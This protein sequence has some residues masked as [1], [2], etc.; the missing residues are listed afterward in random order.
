MSRM[1]AP[2]LLLLAAWFPAAPR[3]GEEPRSLAWCYRTLADVVCYTDPDAGR[4]NRFVGAYPFRPDAAHRLLRERSGRR[5]AALAPT[6]W[7]PAPPRPAHRPP[8][9]A[10]SAPP[11]ATPAEP[12]STSPSSSAP[13]TIAGRGGRSPAVPVMRPP[14]GTVTADGPRAPIPVARPGPPAD[15]GCPPG[16]TAGPRSLLGDG[17]SGCPAEAD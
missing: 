5:A 3:A 7:P 14:V 9:D 11:A 1:L 4:E 13:R 15:A 8:P 10:G 2:A 6:R 12:L 17:D 16:A